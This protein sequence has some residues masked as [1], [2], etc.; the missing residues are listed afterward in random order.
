LERGYLQLG[1]SSTPG[2]Y[3]LPPMLA[4]FRRS[5]PNLEVTFNLGNSREIVEEILKDR[6]D[7]G[8]IEG[9]ENTAGVQVQPFLEDELVMIAPAGHP[10]MGKELIKPDDLEGE[11]FIWREAGSGTRE[12]MA[13]LL[14]Q[15]G[16][17]P[18]NALELGNCEGVKRAVAAGLGLSAVSR[19]AVEMEHSLGM[20]AILNGEGLSFQRSLYI[21]TRKDR[22]LSAAALGF[23]AHL[24]KYD[25]LPST[26]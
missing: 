16:I 25:L 9:H 6:L 8:F 15:I 12:G 2:I 4:R 11:T 1:A 14:E 23:L 21:I 5:Y 22:R 17:H 20:L 18:E 10:L 19:W 3:I 26:E 24:R 7:L 13:T